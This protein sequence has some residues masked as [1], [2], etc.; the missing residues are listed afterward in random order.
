MRLSH[1]Y[2]SRF[3]SLTRFST[4]AHPTKLVQRDLSALRTVLQLPPLS[5][6][7][8]SRTQPQ[9]MSLWRKPG[10]KT[11]QL[12][13]RSQRD[14]L[15]NDP[16]ASDRVLKEIDTSQQ[17]KVRRRRLLTLAVISRRLS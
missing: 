2:S 8:K 15:I 14:P 6:L 13:H 17:K 11:F 3:T 16:D 9:T 10:T 1:L 12:V 7:Q 4:L 5:H